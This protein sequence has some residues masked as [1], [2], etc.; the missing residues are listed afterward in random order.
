[1][2]DAVL[3]PALLALCLARIGESN[4]DSSL[5]QEGVKRYGRALHQ[6]QIALRNPRRIQSDELIAAC[7]LLAIYEMFQGPF[8]ETASSQGPNWL[9]HMFGVSKVVEIRGPDQCVAGRSHRLFIDTRL[10]G[11]IAA[12]SI[13]RPNY[14]SSE[15]WAT[16]PWR[17]T[18]KD[19]KE[20]LHDI[21]AKLPPLLECFDIANR[22]P[23]AAGRQRQHLLVADRCWDMDQLLQQW[24]HSVVSKFSAPLPSAIQ[25]QTDSVSIQSCRDQPRYFRVDDYIEAYMLMLYWTT[26]LL[27]YS[28]LQLNYAKLHAESPSL[29]PERLPD[30][31][32]VQQYAISIAS[33]VEYFIHPD[34]GILGPQFLSFPMGTALFFFELVDEPKKAVYGHRLVSAVRQI[35]QLGLPIGDFLTSMLTH[36]LTT[37]GPTLKGE[38]S[39]QQ[40][41]QKL[42]WLDSGAK[43]LQKTATCT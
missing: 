27:T 13:R 18:E 35:D 2:N 26:C 31:T 4:K 24:C 33:S 14:L 16:E 8:D 40:R 19:L 34:M 22:H 25:M 11:I 15:I 38:N 29:V 3:R 39:C 21:M 9:S 20:E 5:T 41:A 6:T 30:R 17:R 23:H 32:R 28:T 43:P 37:A 10:N 36:R 1:M 7:K 12:I 42:S